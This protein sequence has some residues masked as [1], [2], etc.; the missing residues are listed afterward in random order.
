MGTH[1]GAPRPHPVVVGVSPGQPPHIVLEAAR[2][3]AQFQTEL[4][5]A[6]VTP[7]RFDNAESPNDSM[8]TAP[9]DPDLAEEGQTGFD[10]R[11]KE[12]LSETLRD[13]AVPW[14]TLAAGG[15][16]ATAL[17]QLADT[18]EASMIVIGTRERT[19]TG[20]V[21]ELFSRSVAI[22]L[23]HDQLRPVVV[24][25]ARTAGG[26]AGGAAGSTAAH[27]AAGA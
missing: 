20:S 9:L 6:H 10:A 4:L 22:R 16:V 27:A 5:C 2:F 17:R 21:Q 26:P 3:A 14:R 15:D 23:A 8:L 25:P 18:V 19:F 7:G 1:S 13:C 24:I 12:S 11:L